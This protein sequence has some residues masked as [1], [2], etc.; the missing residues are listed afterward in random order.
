MKNNIDQERAP[1]SPSLLDGIALPPPPLYD[2]LFCIWV[3]FVL[4]LNLYCIGVKLY[5]KTRHCG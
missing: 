4:R 2:V 1:V 3:Y 5:T